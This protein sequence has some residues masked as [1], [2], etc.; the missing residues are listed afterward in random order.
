MEVLYV[1]LPRDM[2]SADFGAI[3]LG[4][5]TVEGSRTVA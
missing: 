3:V 4:I 2:Q 5:L 1:K